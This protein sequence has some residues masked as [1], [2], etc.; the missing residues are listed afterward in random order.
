MKTLQVRNTTG[1]LAVGCIA[2]MFTACDLVDDDNPVPINL[3]VSSPAIVEGQNGTTFLR[4]G[5]TIDPSDRDVEF[6]LRT[7]DGTASSG[8]DF[9]P[10]LDSYMTIPAGSTQAHVDID[11]FGDEDFEN[12]ESFQLW[13]VTIAHTPM[14][15]AVGSGT[16]IN[17]DLERDVEVSASYAYDDLNR[18][19]SV[20]YSNGELVRYT[21]DAA[22]N[23]LTVESE[24]P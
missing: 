23:M 10:I 1:A 22:G 16:I 9:A 5:L 24:V 7:M 15:R 20:Q 2:A 14:E 3:T 19:T 17:D 18:L 6:L 8:S 12:D 13:A 4:F 21:Y 11:I